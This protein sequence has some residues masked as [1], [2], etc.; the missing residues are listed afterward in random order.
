[1][2]A[3]WEGVEGEHKESTI[4]IPEGTDVHSDPKEALLPGSVEGIGRHKTTPGIVPWQKSC[5]ARY[6]LSSPAF[7][8]ED[9]GFRPH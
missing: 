1:M 6:L 5:L 3:L 2:D 8:G 4:Q 9:F 7:G